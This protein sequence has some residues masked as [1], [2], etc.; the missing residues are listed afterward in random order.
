MSRS[1]DADVSYYQRLLARDQD[2]ATQ[3]VLAQA[4]T[5]PPEQVYD[6]LLVPALNYVKR[7][8][9]RD[10]LTE[11]DEQFILR[12]TREIV[13]DLGERQA[14]AAVPGGGGPVPE[15]TAA[16]RRAKS[17]SWGVRA[18]MRRTR[19]LWRCS[20]S[21][22][23]RPGGKWRCCRWT[24]S[25][26]R[27]WPWPGTRSRRSFASA[28]CR[29]ADWR[30]PATCASGCGPGCPRPESWWGAGGSRATWNRIRQQLLEAGADQVE[31]TLLETR[32]HLH[33]LAAG[34]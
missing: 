22:S 34:A 32:T 1:L 30:T 20:A 23:T 8:R 9:E 33:D 3:L 6:G 19:W 12:A 24:C 26:P 11:A 28:L 14:A 5:L 29:R 2:E 31:T 16:R 13:E 15:A 10:D 7:D 17:G 21:C 27:W 18:T 4:K 25:P